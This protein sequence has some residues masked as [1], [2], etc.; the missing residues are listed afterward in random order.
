VVEA[1]EY[2]TAFFDKRS[3]FLHYHPRTLVLNNLEFDHADIFDDLAAIQRQFGHLLRTVPG[4]GRVLSNAQEPALRQVLEAGCWTPVE[5]FS[6]GGA[7][8]GW[9][10]AEAS[11]DGSA[12]TVTLDGAPQGRVAWVLRGPHNMSNALAAIGAARHAGV[13]PAQAIAALSTF[14]GVRRRLE[15]L[16]QVGGITL[17]DDFAHHPTAIASTLAG[18]RAGASGRVLA[19]VEPR[20]NSMRLGVHRAGLAPA[21]ADADLAFVLRPPGLSWDLAAALAPLGERLRLF[22]DIDVLRADVLAE[23]RAGDSAVLMS[24]GAFAGLG[25]A[26]AKALDEQ[27]S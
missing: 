7:P 1:D 15:T 23:L 8:Q 9:G 22:D 19:V 5:D 20:S 26:L 4:S 16:A 27:Y 12:F 17:Y 24:N 14:K 6:G 10:L 13:K 21:L 2:D 11:P 3:K 25:A 18:L